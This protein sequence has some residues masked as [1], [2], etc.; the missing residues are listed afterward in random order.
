MFHIFTLI[1]ATQ[2]WRLGGLQLEASPG[3]K[4]LKTPSQP[5]AGCNSIYLSS[6]YMG[7]I[8]VQVGLEMKGKTL[9]KK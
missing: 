4:S 5:M 3:K 6:S 1:L 7:R 8:V 2:R 9:S